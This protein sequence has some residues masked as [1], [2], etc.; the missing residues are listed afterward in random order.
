MGVE[1]VFQL[2]F[3]FLVGTLLKKKYRWTRPKAIKSL[4]SYKFC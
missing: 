2:K 1:Q 4:H 3:I